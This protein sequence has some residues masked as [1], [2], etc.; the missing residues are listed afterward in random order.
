MSL[1]HVSPFQQSPQLSKP[2][3][4]SLS[5]FPFT[6]L[7]PSVSTMSEG[8]ERAVGVGR[9]GE[10]QTAFAVAT[11]T[12]LMLTLLK[13]YSAGAQTPSPASNMAKPE[14]SLGDRGAGGPPA[15]QAAETVPLAILGGNFVVNRYLLSGREAATHPYP[16]SIPAALIRNCFLKPNGRGT[17]ILNSGEKPYLRC[18]HKPGRVTS[19]PFGVA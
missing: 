6:S 12:F 19:A 5:S 15:V 7:R 14:G 2:L 1:S 9:G 17:C 8:L 13:L 4:C 10:D 11:Q 18:W 16:S 3:L